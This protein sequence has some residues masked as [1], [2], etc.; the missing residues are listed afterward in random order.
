MTAHNVLFVRV[1]QVRPTSV[2]PRYMT[3]GAAAADV[4]ADFGGI[5]DPWVEGLFGSEYEW[6]PSAS[7]R[8]L[9]SMRAL[10]TTIIRI[11][12]GF[13]LE[14]PPTYVAILKGRSGHAM[15]GAD[16][17]VAYIDS[18]FRGEVSMLVRV[19]QESI[20]IRHGERVGQVAFVPVARAQFELVDDLSPSARGDG[21]FGST[22][23]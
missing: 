8:R 4:Y 11:P 6:Y 16:A 14:F 10:P 5:T 21:G 22:G 1:R 13:A 7:S 19:G 3:E 18:D 9:L 23:R 15:I 12:L 2:M 17:H 20:T